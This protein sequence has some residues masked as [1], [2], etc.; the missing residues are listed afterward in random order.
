MKKVLFAIVV[1]VSLSFVF[2]SCE[3]EEEYTAPAMTT[4]TITGVV[5][6][7]LDFTNAVSEF[8]PVGTKL[9]ARVN[10][11]DLVENPIAGYP[12]E[13]IIFT[14]TVGASG[15]YSFTVSAGV[16]VANYTIYGDDFSYNALVTAAPTYMQ[17]YYSLGGTVVS[18]TRGQKILVDLSY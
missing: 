3:K 2:T 6:A 12:Y 4:A 16:P 11:A 14:T 7:E 18:A 10:A 17:L 13:D 9:Y 1:L 8:A 5:E 15:V